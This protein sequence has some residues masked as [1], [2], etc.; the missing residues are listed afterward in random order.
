VA[1]L[2]LSADDAAGKSSRPTL[3][4]R[5]SEGELLSEKAIT[6]QATIMDDRFSLES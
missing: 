1:R 5:T 4:R 3:S 2:L 6:P